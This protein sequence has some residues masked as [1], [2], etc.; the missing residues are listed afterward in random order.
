[1]VGK[2][3]ECFWT[4]SLSGG[5]ITVEGPFYDAGPSKLAITGGTG[6]Y[7]GA[8]GW[9]A[10]SAANQKGTKYNFVFHVL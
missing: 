2:A 6:A 7:A 5:Q 1:V 3:W 8:R 10:L 4:T 9:M